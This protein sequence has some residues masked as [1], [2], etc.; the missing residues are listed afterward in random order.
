MRRTIFDDEHDDFRDAVKTFIAREVVPHHERWREDRLVSRDMWLAAGR[1]GLLGISIPAEHGGAGTEDF[2]F[3][4]VLTEEL[5]RAGLAL[6]SSVGIHTDVVAPYLVE[7]TTEEQRGRW[8]PGFCSGEI[9]TAIGMTE[10][11]AGSDLASMRTTARRDGDGWVLNGSKTFITNGTAADLV[12]VA[13]RTGSG[14]RE[15]TLFAIEEGVEGFTRG[16][17]LHKV[18]QPEAD[19]AELFFEDVHLGGEQVVGELHGG[20]TTMMRHLPQ[21][22]LHSACANIAH[23]AGALEQTLEYAKERQ[24]FGQAIG[25]FQHSRFLLAE[26]VTE[27]E[28]TQTFIDRC[29][30]EY[31]T[32]TLPDVETAKAKWWSA[33]VQ[34]RVIDACVQLHGGYGYMDEYPVARAWADARVTKIWAGSNEIMK[35]V[36]GRSLGLGQARRVS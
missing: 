35:E 16:R 5:A 28:V 9:V 12:V 25:T 4:A 24:A 27:I 17:K 22:R 8:L 31:V 29:V 32:G 11:G 7:C 6:A 14:P 19:T 20:F 33:Q 23:A 3:N 2:R 13:A 10:P 15:I 1:Q 30:A 36:I 26:L 34:N 21:E 18:G